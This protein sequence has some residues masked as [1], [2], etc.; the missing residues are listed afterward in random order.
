MTSLPLPRA[1][2]WRAATST[3]TPA[4]T[5]TRRPRAWPW[6][7]SRRRLW[8]RS[9]PR[10]RPTSWPWPRSGAR[11]RATALAH[12]L[13]LRIDDLL[14]GRKEVAFGREQLQATPASIPTAPIATPARLRVLILVVVATHVGVAVRL[15]LRVRLLSALALLL[16]A[17]ARLAEL[18]QLLGARPLPFLLQLFDLPLALQ[19]L[20]RAASRTRS[21]SR[22]FASR[23]AA[24]F[25]S[26]ASWSSSALSS[27]PALFSRSST[28][29]LSFFRSRASDFDLAD[30]SFISSCFL[31]S[32]ILSSSISSSSF[33]ESA[34]AA[35]ATSDPNCASRRSFS[36]RFFAVCSFFTL[37]ATLV[38]ALICWQ[39]QVRDWAQVQPEVVAQISLPVWPSASW[40]RPSTRSSIFRG[41][42]SPAVRSLLRHAAH[43]G[44]IRGVVALRLLREQ[45]PRLDVVEVRGRLLG[46]HGFNI[47]HWRLERHL[48]GRAW[49]G[50]RLARVRQRS[51]AGWRF[52]EHFWC[53]VRRWLVERWWVAHLRGLTHRWWKVLAHERWRYHRPGTMP[54]SRLAAGEAGSCSEVWS[55]AW[56]SLGAA[57]AAWADLCRVATPPLLRRTAQVAVA[58]E[59]DRGTQVWRA[60]TLVI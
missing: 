16:L 32:R 7:R 37:S 38:S 53:D 20:L 60:R 25:R 15:A 28:I 56:G 45:V 14:V 49:G 39:Q 55:L 2:T 47:E 10:A 26:R 42:L 5:A 35:A 57:V 54:G 23:S 24:R 51:D 33:F 19:L 59:W 4:P 3:A 52:G 21:I 31:R 22:S 43:A 1:R 44:I 9:R 13:Q 36:F 29:S 40:S 12:G 11:L 48:R 30:L 41:S 27:L 18:A 50:R 17:F 34:L 8:P 6:P 46:N 58:G